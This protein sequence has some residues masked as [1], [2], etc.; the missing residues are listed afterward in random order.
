M[1]K[2]DISELHVAHSTSQLGRYH[3]MQ[4]MNGYWAFII[5]LRGDRNAF[6]GKGLEMEQRV[7]LLQCHQPILEDRFIR[8]V[9]DNLSGTVLLN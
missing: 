6:Y 9:G 3:I 8:G 4:S 7:L 5:Q 1:K 2:K